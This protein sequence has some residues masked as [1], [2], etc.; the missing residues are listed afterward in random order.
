MS[1]KQQSVDDGETL[2]SRQRQLIAE[3]P[4]RW[5]NSIAEEKRQVGSVSQDGEMR[6]RLFNQCD[7]I[8]TKQINQW[9]DIVDTTHEILAPLTRCS[10]RARRRVV[11]EI[12]ALHR[13]FI[14]WPKP[15][16]SAWCDGSR[17]GCALATFEE[18][19]TS[20]IIAGPFRIASSRSEL[21]PRA[22]CAIMDVAR[23]FTPLPR[24]WGWY[25]GVRTF[26]PMR[27]VSVWCE[28]HRQNAGCVRADLLR[29]IGWNAQLPFVG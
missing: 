28:P 4:Y 3:K 29:A 25:P 10:R 8:L 16:V 14:D 13:Q 5:D 24:V 6:Y 20:I 18:P 2:L 9:R 1:L 26:T 27:D 22:A 12:L 23:G 21:T 15:R 19:R 17:W 7:C 11:R